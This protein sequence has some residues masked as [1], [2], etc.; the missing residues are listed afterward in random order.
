M[1]NRNDREYDLTHEEREEIIVSIMNFCDETDCDKCK[2][3]E[4]GFCYTGH[5]HQM[6]SNKLLE[7]MACIANIN[8]KLLDEDTKIRLEEVNKKEEQLEATNPSHYK[9]NLYECIDEMKLVFGIDAL[10]DFCKLNAWKYRYRHD[11]KN[12]KEDLAKADWYINKL[13]ELQIEKL[14]SKGVFTNNE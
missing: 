10:M 8:T 13:N 9:T 1:E 14:Q 5:W 12:K 11:N 3:Y 6:K 4:T 7:T 2:V